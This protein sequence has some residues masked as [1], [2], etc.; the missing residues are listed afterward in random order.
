M[1]SEL[2][3]AIKALVI[4]AGKQTDGSEAMRFSQAA[5]NLAHTGS[6]VRGTNGPDLTE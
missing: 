2:K 6:V 5:L 1:N 4:L 3:E